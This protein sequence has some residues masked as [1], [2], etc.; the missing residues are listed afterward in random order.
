MLPPNTSKEKDTPDLNKW[1]KNPMKGASKW[2]KI[3]NKMAT[4]GVT[5]HLQLSVMHSSGASEEDIQNKKE[6]LKN[7]S[8]LNLELG[9]EIYKRVSY[10]G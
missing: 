4:K 7:L 10:D 2:S 5:S 8:P 9:N 3:K 1:K 6:S